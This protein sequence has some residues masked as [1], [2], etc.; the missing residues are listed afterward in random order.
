MINIKQDNSKTIQKEIDMKLTTYN[1]I[2]CKWL[3]DNDPINNRKNHIQCNFVAYKD[4]KAI[5]GAIGFIDYS[6]YFLDLLWIE[7]EYRGQDV[8]TILIRKIENYSME[9]NLIG[10]R[11]ETWD[12]QARGFYEKM[13]YEVYA[14]LEDCPPGTIDYYLKKTIKKPFK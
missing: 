13:G 1:R 5:G 7:E 6:W 11:M 12:F 9:N 14:K 4:E 8:G 3:K 10:I 2:Q